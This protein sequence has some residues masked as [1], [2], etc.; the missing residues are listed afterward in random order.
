M[1]G[2]PRQSLCPESWE[3]GERVTRCCTPKLPLLE[4]WG[5]RKVEAQDAVISKVFSC[6][7][8]S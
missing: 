8:I 7:L 2:H 1:A 4:I 3:M 5:K 6:P